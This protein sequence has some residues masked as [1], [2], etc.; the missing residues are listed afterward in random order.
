MEMTGYLKELKYQVINL[1][2]PLRTRALWQE[3]WRAEL[4]LAL[5][6]QIARDS[7]IPGL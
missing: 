5:V 4:L 1:P 3:R 6:S 2:E 7:N